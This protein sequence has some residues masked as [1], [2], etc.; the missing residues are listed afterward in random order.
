MKFIIIKF[1]LKH[2]TKTAGTGA[3]NAFRQL[4]LFSFLN[5]NV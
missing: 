4:F 2:N 5:L 1:N 3:L